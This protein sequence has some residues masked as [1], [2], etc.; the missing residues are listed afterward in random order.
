MPSHGCNFQQST[1]E[2]RWRYGSALAPDEGVEEST[3]CG[4]AIHLSGTSIVRLFAG[5]GCSASY[6][7]KGRGNTKG[8]Q[9]FDRGLAYRI[10]LELW[11]QNARQRVER[12]SRT[13]CSA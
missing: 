10:I 8:N 11:L 9:A 1:S 13:V 3:G 7:E 5:T 2:M 4:H 6:C 12:S